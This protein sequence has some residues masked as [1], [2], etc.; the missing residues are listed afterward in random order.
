DESA[1][2]GR[3]RHCTVRLTDLHISRVHCETELEGPLLYVTDL[4]SVGG[5]L[6]N[7]KRITDQVAHPGDVIQV[8][9]TQLRFLADDV[10]DKPTL[11]PPA[12]A[13]SLPRDRLG[14]LSGRIL[15]H[16]QVGPI[17]ARAQSGI[18]FQARD[19]KDD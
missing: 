19:F 18:V 11:P 7:A 12:A 2:I 13:P 15:S 8:G 16:F 5:T 9:E 10:A 1:I 6:V 17:V 14:E 3:G 4:D